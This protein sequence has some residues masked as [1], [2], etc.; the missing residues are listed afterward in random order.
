MVYK[1]R[2]IKVFKPKKKK[3]SIDTVIGKLKESYEQ[4]II[5]TIFKLNIIL[6]YL[7]IVYCKMH[8]I[9]VILRK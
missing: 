6:I 3:E 7:I 9:I 4:V 1:K 8:I 2:K 5:L